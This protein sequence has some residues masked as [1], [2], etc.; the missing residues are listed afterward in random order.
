MS[1]SAL[2]GASDHRGLS[3]VRVV[4]LTVYRDTRGALTYAQVPDQLPF[5]AVRFFLLYDLEMEHTR[6]SHAHRELEQF[7]VCVRGVCRVEL[8]DGHERQSLV[9][10]QPG[11]GVY[12]PRMV[13]TTV[14][15][16]AADAIV[17]VLTS[18]RYD[19]ADYVRDY[20][21]FVRLT[22]RKPGT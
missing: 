12:V 21:E 17:L 7:L 19:A 13:W 1:E 10:D 5:V 9:L 16:L 20:D 14:V 8:D 18:H 3:D 4:E 6:G 11:R 2:S 22:R 15:P